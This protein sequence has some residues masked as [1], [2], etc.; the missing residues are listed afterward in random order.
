[1]ERGMF[2]KQV[3]AVGAMLGVLCS[4]ISANAVDY[5]LGLGAGVAP[6]YEGSE[7]YEAV[8]LWNLAA[9]DLYH[10]ETYVRI[11]GPTLRSNFIPHE[12]FRL[13]LA[14]QYVAKRNDV[15]NNT[16]DSLRST[17]DGVML[18]ALLGYDFKLSGNRVIGVEFEPRWDVEDSIGGQFTGRVAYTA[19]FGGGSWIFNASAETTYASGAYMSE[20]F[21]INA[22]DSA[23]SGLDT[24]DADADFKDAGFGVT[25]TYKFTD[26]WNVTGLAR[27]TR[28]LGDAADSPVVDDEGDENQLFGGL[29]IN[30]SF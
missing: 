14:G 16:V 8:P 26:S 1:M 29:T 30:Y 3:L 2:R 10:P 18:G 23:R 5:T 11:F 19:P 7:D 22:A 24:F 27:Y 28:L 9:K 4:S 13:G 21:S 12:N 15:E 20:Y 25:L 17:D 6:D